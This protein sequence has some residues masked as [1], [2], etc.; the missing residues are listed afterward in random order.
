MLARWGDNKY[1]GL[2]VGQVLV[3]VVVVIIVL[4]QVVHCAG[5][6][7][8]LLLPAI[9]VL[10]EHLHLLLDQGVQVLAFRKQNGQKKEEYPLVHLLDR[11][12]AAAA[13]LILVFRCRGGTL[14]ALQG[15]GRF[16]VIQV[17]GRVRILAHLSSLCVSS[18]CG[19]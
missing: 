3:R 19:R 8:F 16:D 1:L 4:V 9:F 5:V 11:L 12:I 17:R 18:R 7:V 14:G 15:L 2:R 13:S 6:L 10:P